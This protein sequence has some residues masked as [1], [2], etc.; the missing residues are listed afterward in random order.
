MVDI[1]YLYAITYCNISSIDSGKIGTNSKV[2]ITAPY[3]IKNKAT[4]MTD[5]ENM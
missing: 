1:I 5:D 4:S 2:S 3:N